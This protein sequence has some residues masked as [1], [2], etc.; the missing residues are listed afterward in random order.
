MPPDSLAADSA[1]V[2]LPDL[3]G[4]LPP[5]PD[6]LA[7]VV[8]PSA[9]APR[10]VAEVLPD[11][12][13]RSVADAK[14][15]ATAASEAALKASD[16]LWEHVIL[17]ADGVT[18]FGA[19][20]TEDVLLTVAVAVVLWALRTA[21][22]AAVKRNA[23]D[24]ATLYHWRKGSLYAAVG[25]GLVLLVPLW[26]GA[27]GSLA[28]FLGLLSAGLAIALRDP[29]AGVF[30]WFYILGRRPFAPGDRVTVRGHTGDVTDVRLLGFTLLEVDAADGAGQSTGRIIHVPNGWV[31]SESLV[32][33]TAAFA[34]VWHEVAVTVT[35]ES[36]WRVA[37]DDLLRIARERAEAFS[38][39]AEAELRR[40]AS[41]HFI[42]YAQLT[43]TVYTSVDE[44]GVRLTL[45]YLV[46]PRAVRGSEQAVWEDI[47]DAVAARD[48]VAFAYRTQRLFNAPA[49]TKP[50]LRVRE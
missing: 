2:R 14:R 21:T 15:A 41:E 13:L 18:G 17:A 45:R 1:D 48:S 35:H 50:G 29:I 33:H 10:A 22:L 27:V 43:P 40:S 20:I 36:D 32:N 31:F 6:A 11:T 24:P 38:P 3:A 39:D 30:G 44:N 49:E 26:G 19:E 37:K 28:T 46:R 23:T 42:V 7:A 5:V 34:Y 4:S 25:L 9:V 16:G 8:E 12:L 47:L